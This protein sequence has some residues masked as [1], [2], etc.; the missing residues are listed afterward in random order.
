MLNQVEFLIDVDGC[1]CALTRKFQE[2][3]PFFDKYLL[4]SQRWNGVLNIH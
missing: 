4:P 1:V 2:L 3:E